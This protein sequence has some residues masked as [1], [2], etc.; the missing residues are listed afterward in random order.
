MKQ[1]RLNAIGTIYGAGE[2]TST[3]NQT[4]ADYYGGWY[5]KNFSKTK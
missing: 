1:P 4:Y 2:R 5:D 3:T